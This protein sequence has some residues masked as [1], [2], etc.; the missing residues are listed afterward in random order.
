MALVARR[1]V[2]KSGVAGT[3]LVMCLGLERDRERSVEK[4]TKKE[5]ESKHTRQPKKMLFGKFYVL[6]QCAPW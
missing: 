5:T 6:L 3:A 2:H 4:E 1:T